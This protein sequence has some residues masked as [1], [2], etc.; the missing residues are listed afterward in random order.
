LPD[1]TA[2]AARLTADV[3]LQQSEVL[4]KAA[5]DRARDAARRRDEAEA[6]AGQ[7]NELETAVIV[8]KEGAT[9]ARLVLHRETRACRD[10]LQRR[11][12]CEYEKAAAAMVRALAVLKAMSERP[13]PG[14]DWSVLESA[15]GQIMVPALRHQGAVA[16]VEVLW[17]RPCHIGRDGLILP[18]HTLQAA[19]RLADDM[20]QALAGG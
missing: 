16:P 18:R 6:A 10:N 2:T 3:V 1:L 4:R 13:S 7:V 12:L 14:E 9:R 11:A 8:A 15:L 20:G 19:Q 5:R 17:D